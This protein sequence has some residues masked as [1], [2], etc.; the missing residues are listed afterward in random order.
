MFSESCEILSSKQW[1]R[2]GRRPWKPPVG[3]QV[4]QKLWVTWTPT[5]CNR[6]LN[7]GRA[8]SRDLICRF[9]HCLWIESARIELSCRTLTWCQ[10]ELRGVG[11]SLHTFGYLEVFS[12]S[13]GDELGF[14]LHR[15][16]IKLSTSKHMQNVFSFSFFP[17]RNQ[18]NLLYY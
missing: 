8:V 14:S 16:Q 11:K 4:R 18:D 10:G 12:V 9:R 3:S 2:R 7:R 13:K 15:R 1:N 6:H 5:T 17:S